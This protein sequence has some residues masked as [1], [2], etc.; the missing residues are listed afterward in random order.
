MEDQGS[1]NPYIIWATHTHRGGNVYN[2]A[3]KDDDT[4][5]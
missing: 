3:W 5:A 1:S 4:Q 2:F